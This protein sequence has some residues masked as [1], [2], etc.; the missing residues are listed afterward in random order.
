[1]KVWLPP[2]FINGGS[3]TEQAQKDAR[4][5]SQPEFYSKYGDSYVSAIHK[6]GNLYGMLH[7]SC[8]S[9]NQKMR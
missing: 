9:Y 8:Q 1:M 7:I 4:N 2:T 6:G 3:L 5:M